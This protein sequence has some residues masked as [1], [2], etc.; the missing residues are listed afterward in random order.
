M[1]IIEHDLVVAVIEHLRLVHLKELKEEARFCG[2]RPNA[3]SA[4][5]VSPEEVAVGLFVLV[6]VNFK[7]AKRAGSRC[8]GKG[9]RRT[10]FMMGGISSNSTISCVLAKHRVCKDLGS[11]EGEFAS[12][13]TSKESV[14]RRPSNPWELAIFIV[15][16]CYEL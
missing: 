7:D 4:L 11:E 9:K 3:T 5:F 14:T 1:K 10:D 13:S 2:G 15:K 16:S 6:D 12:M 8:G